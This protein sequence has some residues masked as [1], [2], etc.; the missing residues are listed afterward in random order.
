VLRSHTTLRALVLVPLLAAAVDQAR[1]GIACGGAAASCLEAAGQGWLGA[2]GPVLLVVY[3][4]A[5]AIGVARLAGGAAATAGGA[6][7]GSFLLRW[8]IGTAGVL[9]VCG[10]QAALAAVLGAGG[11]LGGGWLLLCGLAVVAGLLVALAL[12]VAP[13]AGALARGLAPRA[14]RPAA[15]PSALPS[16]RTLLLHRLGRRAAPLLQGRGP[17]RAGLATAR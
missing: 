2:A 14:P 5:L 8:A 3:A 16:T 15:V 9:A 13:A 1:A 12:R 11:G 10:G 7:A 4:L 6:P 17:P